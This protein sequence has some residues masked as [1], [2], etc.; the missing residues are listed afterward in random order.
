MRRLLQVRDFGSFKA[1]DDDFVLVD[2]GVEGAAPAE[3][4][5]EPWLAGALVV[6]VVVT[7]LVP[8]PEQLAAR[9]RAREEDV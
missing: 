6:V 8:P 1:V 2:D 5:A 4:P 3:L 9:A 7:V